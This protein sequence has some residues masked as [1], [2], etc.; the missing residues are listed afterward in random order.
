MWR[1][2]SREGLG[3]RD[4]AKDFGMSVV[5]DPPELERTRSHRLGL[6][7]IAGSVGLLVAAGLLL[8]HRHGAAV[9]SDTVLAALAWCF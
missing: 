6:G 2:A 4:L 9:F 7:L 1:Q 3:T 8:W 5:T